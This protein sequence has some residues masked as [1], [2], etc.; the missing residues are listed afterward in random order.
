MRE[1]RRRPLAGAG[2]VTRRQV[3][4]AAGALGLLAFIAPACATARSSEENDMADTIITNARVTTLD[5]ANPEGQ[6]VA[7]R[8]GL[9]QAVGPRDE[10]MRLANRRT[11]VI[12]AGGRRVIPGLNDSHTHLIRGGLNYNMELRWEGVPS[13]ADALRLLRNQADRTPA[14]TSRV[15]VT[16]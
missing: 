16:T 10:I 5:H 3:T 13:L 15:R 2:S 1:N 4:K 6:A 8:D 12:D 14:P 11:R 9:I 7:V